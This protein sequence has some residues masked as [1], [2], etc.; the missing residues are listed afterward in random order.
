MDYYH[1]EQHILKKNYKTYS[2]EYWKNIV[3]S[4]NTLIFY[5]VI[6]TNLD[7]LDHHTFFFD[8]NKNYDYIFSNTINLDPV[9]YVS[10]IIDTY[11]KL[12]ILVP[13]NYRYNISLKEQNIIY[14]NI[15]NRIDLKCSISLHNHT[16][17]R[18]SMDPQNFTTLYNGY[19]GNAFGVAN[20]LNQSLYLK[21]QMTSRIKNLVYAG[22]MTQSGPGIPPCM[23][24]GIVAS[25]LLD[26]KIQEDSY[27]LKINLSLLVFTIITICFTIGLYIY[28][29][30][31]Y[32]SYCYAVYL[33]FIHGKTYFDASLLFTPRKL[34]ETASL[35]G[36]F[37]IVDDIVDNNND[38]Y[39]KKKE[40]T[41]FITEFNTIRNNKVIDNKVL[42][43][44]NPIFPATFETI[45]KYNFN[46]K[47]F[48]RFFKSM[49]MDLEISRYETMNELLDY[50]DGSAAVIGEFMIEI[51]IDNKEK[52][53]IS[54][55]FAKALGIAFQL[56][57]MIRDIREDF[58]MDRVYMPQKIL[59]KF[60]IDISSLIDTEEQTKNN[61][62]FFEHMFKETDYYYELGNLGIYYI[63]YKYKNIVY[64]AKKSYHA[65]HAQI[66]SVDYN[67]VEKNKISFIEKLYYS[68]VVGYKN[69][70]IISVSYVLY[71]IAYL[72]IKY[73]DIIVI[74]YFYSLTQI[75]NISNLTYFRFHMLFTIPCLCI[76]KIITDIQSYF[77]KKNTNKIRIIYNGIV[78]LSFIANIYTFP[79]DYYL[80][81]HKIWDY[82]EDK[83]MSTF[84]SIPL[85]EISFFSLQ[86]FLCSL[87]WLY[88]YNKFGISNYD[89]KNNTKYENIYITFYSIALIGLTNYLYY[90]DS[91]YTY[92]NFIVTWGTPII[93][94]Q[95]SYNLSNIINNYTLIFNSLATSS[96]LLVIFDIFAIDNF[97]WFINKETSYYPFTDYIATIPLEEITFFIIT[98]LMCILGLTQYIVFI[99]KIVNK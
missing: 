86:T 74:I 56:T 57:N 67:I 11:T 63:P 98:S 4:P 52:K 75:L 34:V 62:S 64:F 69:L 36:I 12:F 60:N 41:Q 77:S 9:F 72:F 82:S 25:D 80:I 99:N 50:M 78:L 38:I 81:K 88:N 19:R 26:K 10:K 49:N 68:R 37:R 8:K 48:Y 33:F 43:M 31:L 51:L 53:E 40:L 32:M 94:I 70:L 54:R 71:M 45:Q 13:I 83:I 44:K 39:M 96:V 55:P 85:E 89:I 28:S 6:D 30:Y 92:L 35:Y 46:T 76:F 79:W 7:C 1:M 90:R 17:Y 16:I 5:N 3:L 84:C 93:F 66:R 15:V 23:V 87:I 73:I 14:N 95:L 91:K 22:Q 20:T 27:I 21:P 65:I 61:I 97:T 59:N 29:N 47:L 42:F 58:L 24:S 18:N 2:G